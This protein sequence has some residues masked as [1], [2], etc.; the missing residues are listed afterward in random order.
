MRP[1]TRMSKIQGDKEVFLIGSREIVDENDD[2]DLDV[3]SEGSPLGEAIMGLKVGDKT[4][5]VAPNGKEIKVE[6]VAV[7][8]YRV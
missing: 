2:D 7:K 5:Y 8:P 6:V 3:W 4:T 1:K